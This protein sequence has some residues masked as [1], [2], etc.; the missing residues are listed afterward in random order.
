M[1][2]L[3]WQARVGSFTEP[4]PGF[5]AMASGLFFIGVG[6]LMVL[7]RTPSGVRRSTAA[8]GGGVAW[9]GRR[10]IFTAALLFGYA[11]VL[12]PLRYVLAT[13]LLMWLRGDALRLDGAGPV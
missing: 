6:L 3:A 13:F 1:C 10:L 2:L 8:S 11:M 7:S 12:E 4:G 9:P 5:V